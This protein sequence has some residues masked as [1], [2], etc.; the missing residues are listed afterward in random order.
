MRRQVISQLINVAPYACPPGHPESTE[1]LVKLDE[2]TIISGSSD[3]LIRVCSI[4]PNKLL[5][6]LGSHSEYPIER[7]ALSFDG[8]MLVS[9]SHD[10]S[11]KLWDL[12]ADSDADEEKHE[13]GGKDE[14]ETQEALQDA[15][16]AEPSLDDVDLPDGH[17]SSSGS[18]NSKASSTD[19]SDSDTSDDNNKRKKKSRWRNKAAERPQKRRNTFFDG[20]V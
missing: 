19:D 9:A 3:G 17:D 14:E 6:V 16:A 20:L 10:Q 13:H 12:T 2:D 8:S 4:Q 18:D 5:G 11:V 7:L 15:D 1:T